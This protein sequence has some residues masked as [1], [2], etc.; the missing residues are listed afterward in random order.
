M[1]PSVVGAP[2]RTGAPQ[3]I[4]EIPTTPSPTTMDPTNVPTVF[5]TFSSDNGA[6]TEFGFVPSNQRQ[7]NFSPTLHGDNSA[8]AWEPIGAVLTS[9]D[10][11][12][13]GFGASVALSASGGRAFVGADQHATA[14]GARVGYAEAFA[15]SGGINFLRLGNN[16][17]RLLGDAPNALFGRSV[18]T[19]ANGDIF[20]IGGSGFV[21][22]FEL[23]NNQWTTYADRISGLSG[24]GSSLSL[25][26]DGRTLAVGNPDD[27]QVTI[28]ETTESPNGNGARQWQPLAN[29]LDFLETDETEYG[30]VV[31]LSGDGL[32]VCAGYVSSNL[33][34]QFLRIFTLNE[35][36]DEWV[37]L[38]N[39]D[40]TIPDSST[41]AG[42][43]VSPALSDNGRIVAVG[44]ASVTEPNSL[45]VFEYNINTAQWMPRGANLVSTDNEVTD[46]DFAKVVAI[47]ANGNTVAVSSSIAAGMSDHAI[48]FQWHDERGLWVVVDGPPP[49]APIQSKERHGVALSSNGRILAVST[50]DVGQANG[51]VQLY[52]LEGDA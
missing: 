2:V 32:V 10:G 35:A 37:R 33:G 18:A 13:D 24:F 21:D 22:S 31:S 34:N 36:R 1:G 20:V 14:E 30:R 3:R 5:P 47:S 23:V 52:K 8:A 43:S 46:V 45:S 12:T 9:V 16:N 50:T 51:A 41:V 40:L 15:P 48:V 29:R 38:G 42:S 17:G 49:N 28:Y 7:D 6:P 27:L 25:S 4:P 39:N 44:L 19:S 26:S 11:T